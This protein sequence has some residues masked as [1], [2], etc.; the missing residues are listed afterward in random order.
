[1]SDENRILNEHIL[2]EEKRLMG[3]ESRL[4]LQL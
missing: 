1:M 2:E 3:I 4:A